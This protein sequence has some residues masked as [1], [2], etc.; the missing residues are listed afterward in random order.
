MA[1]AKSYADRAEIVTKL[2]ARVRLQA[3]RI[4]RRALSVASKDPE[5][6]EK[7]AM[8]PRME[9][10]FYLHAAMAINGDTTRREI[11]KGGANAA[12]LNVFIMGQAPTNEAWLQAVKEHQDPK[13]IEA[14]I[15]APKE[16]EK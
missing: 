12:S 16:P 1:S 13:L 4:M 3:L 14:T 5:R 7:D 6:V 2:N 9:A 10:P 11:E 8:L 15:A